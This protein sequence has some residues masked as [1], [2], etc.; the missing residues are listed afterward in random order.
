MLNIPI[1]RPNDDRDD[2]RI[3][4]K[5]LREVPGQLLKASPQLGAK[6]NLVEELRM[7]GD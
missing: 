4:H 6:P 3:R 2:D 7:A 5:K 1:V